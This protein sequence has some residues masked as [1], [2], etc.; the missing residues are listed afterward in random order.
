MSSV[1]QVAQDI[2]L[3]TGDTLFIL[4]LLEAAGDVFFNSTQD[5]EKAICFYR[6]S[7]Y[8]QRE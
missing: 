6:V 4:E 8:M 7:L 5:R 3:S 1:S 2:A